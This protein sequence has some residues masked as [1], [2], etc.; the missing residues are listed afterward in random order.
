MN[1]NRFTTGHYEFATPAELAR[2][3]EKA[4]ASIETPVDSAQWSAGLERLRSANDALTSRGGAA[5]FVHM[6]ISGDLRRAE[7][8]RFPRALFWNTIEAA[9]HVPTIHFEDSP[10]LAGVTCADGMHIDGK[11]QSRFT[12]ALV[13]ILRRRALL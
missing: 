10:V 7:N 3:E 9:T 11:D 12:A 13:D 8:E 4:V 5:V 6:P 1:R 2:R